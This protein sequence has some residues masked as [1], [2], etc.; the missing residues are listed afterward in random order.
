MQKHVYISDAFLAGSMYFG[1]LFKVWDLDYYW[2]TSNYE[3]GDKY[4]QSDQKIYKFF[5]SKVCLCA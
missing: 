3:N 5:L 4:Y 1:R 2:M